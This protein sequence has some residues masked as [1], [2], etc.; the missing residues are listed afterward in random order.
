MTGTGRCAIVALLMAAVGCSSTNTGTTASRAGAAPADIDALLRDDLVLTSD[1][2]AAPHGVDLYAMPAAMREEIDRRIGG[3]EDEED[4]YRALRRWIFKV[5]DGYQYDPEVTAAIAELEEIGR[6][7]C[8]SFSVLYVAA[9]RHL[10]LTA[11]V[12][13]VYS[14]PNWDLAADNWV[15]NQH[16]NVSGTVRGSLDDKL[17]QDRMN[18]PTQTGTRI[19]KV[20]RTSTIKYVV[21]L[22]P[23]IIVNAHRTEALGDARVLGRFYANKAA[24]ALVQDDLELAY[25]YSRLGIEADPASSP[26]WTNLGVIYSRLE[27][28]ELAR[29]SYLAALD[30]DP[31]AD[32]ARNNLALLYYSLGDAEQAAALEKVIQSR[33]R[34]NPYYHHLLGENERLAG[35]Y[36]LAMDHYHAA[37]R[38]KRDEP[39]FY[40]SMA[41]AQ[42]ALDRPDDARATLNRA[43]KHANGEDAAAIAEL[44]QQLF[45]GG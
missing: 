1:A 38:R 42:L 25:R 40:M 44:E 43:R 22:N 32:S 23:K 13:L 11:D 6:I 15:L 34:R 14:P 7:N 17:L 10:G 19:Y 16:I 24:E 27:Q 31:D 30:A 21:D 12:Q 3:I 36:D 29:R 5:A 4:R 9:A 39:R 41:E 45:A 37:I 8:F 26:V 20:N 33:R 28:P 35:R 18:L 2:G